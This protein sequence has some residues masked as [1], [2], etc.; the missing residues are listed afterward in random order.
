MNQQNRTTKVKLLALSSHGP[1][2]ES[3]EENTYIPLTL[4]AINHVKTHALSHLT[5]EEVLGRGEYT[6]EIT[7]FEKDLQQVICWGDNTYS[8]VTGFPYSFSSN[9]FWIFH[10]LLDLKYIHTLCEKISQLSSDIELISD[11]HVN[12]SIELK[13]NINSLNFKFFGSG[14]PHFVNFLAIGIKQLRINELSLTQSSENI[15]KFNSPLSSLIKRS[16]E[17]IKRRALL[18]VNRLRKKARRKGAPFQKVW[19]IQEGYDVKILEESFLE[20]QFSNPLSRVLSLPQKQEVSQELPSV[21]NEF[22]NTQLPLFREKLEIFFKSYLHLIQSEGLQL[23]KKIEDLLMEDSPTALF[24]SL[25]ASTFLEGLF[26][27]KAAQAKIPVFFFKHGG[28]ENIFLKESYLEQF[29]ERNQNIERIQFVHAKAELD[30]YKENDK[31]Q[32]HPLGPLDLI[33]PKLDSKPKLNRVLYSV[34]PPAHWS[35]K[36]IHKITLDSERYDFAIGLIKACQENKVPLDIKTHPAEWSHLHNFFRKVIPQNSGVSLISGGTIDRIFPK[37]T[38][39]VLDIICT[40]VLSSLLYTDL[41]ILI[42]APQGL[43]VNEE[44][45]PLLKLRVHVVSTQEEVFDFIQNYRMGKVARKAGATQFN[46]LFTSELPREKALA[47]ALK[48]IQSS[49]SET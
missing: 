2:L 43:G 13:V 3:S 19:K 34:G 41:E 49:I 30:F 1:K 22:I 23:G 6:K 42:F 35:F 25:G 36:D 10:R 8:G 47:R 12:E 24:Y 40:R 39:V 21:I 7:R 33:T 31:I 9:G 4:S 37:Y 28:V 17:I 27:F 11:I 5:L 48:I 38:L 18:F 32:A 44:T 45:F 16:P 46:A 15:G 14:L 29:F 20:L 26:C